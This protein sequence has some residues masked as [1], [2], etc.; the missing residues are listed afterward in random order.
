MRVAN[1]GI[2]AVVDAYGRTVAS[3]P[4]GVEGVLDA[5]LPRP[6]PAT[7]YAWAGDAVFAG[8]LL[9]FLAFSRFRIA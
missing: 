4:L 8:M 5:A 1:T 9:I 2:S 7:F 6:G 3:L